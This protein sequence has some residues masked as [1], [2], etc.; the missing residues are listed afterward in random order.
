MA[1][2]RGEMLMVELLQ[3]VAGVVELRTMR[4]RLES[5]R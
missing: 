3:A 4:A 1:R 5:Q 2:W